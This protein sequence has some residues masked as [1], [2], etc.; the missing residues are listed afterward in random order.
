MMRWL[1]VVTTL[2][3]GACA[4]PPPV[5]P[6]DGASVASGALARSGRFA[7][8]VDEISGK[9]NAVQGGFAWRD[10]GRAL[11]LDLTSPVGATLARVD[12]APNGAALLTEANGTQTAAATADELVARVL[13]SPIPVG[14][15]RDWLRGHLPAN[16]PATI[17][18]RDAEGRP[19]AYDQAGWRVRVNAYDA[20][21]PVRLEMQ[22]NEPGHGV[23]NVRLVITPAS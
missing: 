3:L 8:R 6:V 10:D 15:L 20:T 19:Q 21:G 16:P 12:V 17:V 9:Q 2:L 5:V 11:V 13:G 4:A 1:V 22:R 23:I 7:L 14:G 18:E